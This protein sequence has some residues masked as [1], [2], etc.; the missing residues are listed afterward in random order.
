MLLVQQR[1]AV[2]A[3]LVH[4]PDLHAAVVAG[5][6]ERVGAAAEC[7]TRHGG[8]VPLECVESGHGGRLP[9]VD[10]LDRVPGGED[11]AT[12]AG[13]VTLLAAPAAHHTEL[14]RTG[15][16]VPH[17]QPR[18]LAGAVHPPDVRGDHGTGQ[19][20]LVRLVSPVLHILSNQLT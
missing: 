15:L 6:V 16:Q 4:R 3:G 10:E 20:Q 14:P 7:E 1:H 5:A 19:R 12:V 18:V 17:H 8:P 11:W 2:Q 9:E 13:V